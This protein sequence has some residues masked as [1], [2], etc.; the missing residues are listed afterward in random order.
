MAPRRPPAAAQDAAELTALWEEAL[1]A[2]GPVAQLRPPEA[3]RVTAASAVLR[4]GAADGGSAAAGTAKYINSLLDDWAS[5][6]EALL[7]SKALPHANVAGS[8]DARAAA[9][10]AFSCHLRPVACGCGPPTHR[11]DRRLLPK[12]RR[13]V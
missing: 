5:S 8:G 7:P 3:E 1:G 4:S 2:F 13:A 11:V 9:A 10:A 6:V 12:S